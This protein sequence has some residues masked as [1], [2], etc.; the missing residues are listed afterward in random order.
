[1]KVRI[2][3]VAAAVVSLNLVP[4]P[5]GGSHNCTKEEPRCVDRRTL[6]E[7]P[8]RQVITSRV[9]G[10]HC[11]DDFTAGSPERDRRVLYS[12]IEVAFSAVTHRSGF[13]ETITVSIEGEEP[14]AVGRVAAIGKRSDFYAADWERRDPGS[15]LTFDVRKKVEFAYNQNTGDIGQY[16]IEHRPA[17]YGPAGSGQAGKDGGDPRPGGRPSI[18]VD[19]EGQ[20]G[21]ALE[22]VPPSAPRCRK[23]GGP[24][25][26]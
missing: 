14:H 5:A 2:V 26:T 7:K 8:E 11:Y 1:M 19:C 25:P 17:A 6:V 16:R 12:R 22:V 23:P 20:H 3:L 9:L 10:H 13:L 18:S 15:K 4:R 21:L 24:C